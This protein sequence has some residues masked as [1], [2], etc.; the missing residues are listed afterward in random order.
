MRIKI[1]A[2][3]L[4]IDREGF[5][6]SRDRYLGTCE[7]DSVSRA[8]QMYESELNPDEPEELVYVHADEVSRAAAALGAIKTEK[9]AASSRENGRLGG[10]PRIAP[11]YDMITV[12]ADDGAEQTF[13]RAD[14][15]LSTD[16]RYTLA[17]WKKALKAAG[18]TTAGIV[19][20]EGV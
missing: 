13:D 17:Q 9:K 10:R 12:T 16:E 6:E 19:S 11:R 3:P 7:C 2:R 20:I 1:Y 15:G 18:Y 14:L 8:L 4:D 5:G